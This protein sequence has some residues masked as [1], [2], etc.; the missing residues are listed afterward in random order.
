MQG[1]DEITAT[2]KYSLLHNYYLCNLSDRSS[3]SP[4]DT[5]QAGKAKF[6]HS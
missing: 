5:P 2:L 4:M 3:I 1:K 6:S